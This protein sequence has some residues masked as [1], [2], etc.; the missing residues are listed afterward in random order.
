MLSLLLYIRESA[1]DLW[2]HHHTLFGTAGGSI[3]AAS[4]FDLLSGAAGK[5][6]AII[7]CA[8]AIWALCERIQNWIQ[9]RRKR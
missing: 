6:G 4:W 1:S 8:L 7:G 5:L 2:R 3:A 9:A